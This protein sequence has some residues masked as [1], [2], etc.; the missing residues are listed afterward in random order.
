MSRLR[1][2]KSRLL[3]T[4]ESEKAE[5]ALEAEKFKESL[6]PFRVLHKWRKTVDSIS[7]NKLVVL[8]AQLAYSILNSVKEKKAEAKE[9][10]ADKENN[11]T[12]QKGQAKTNVIN[13]LKEVAKNFV[14]I[15]SK[16][17]EK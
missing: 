7:E 16:K 1:K 13:F 10:I 12:S 6:W 11:S 3:L 5:I 4:I 8:G 17:E 2:E 14:D 9:E 15:Y